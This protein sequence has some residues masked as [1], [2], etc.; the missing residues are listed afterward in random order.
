MHI[1]WKK[2]LII[3][4][5]WLFKIVTCAAVAIT[6]YL[7]MDFTCI[8]AHGLLFRS[9]SSTIY[10]YNYTLCVLATLFVFTT[11]N[12]SFV[13]NINFMKYHGV[14]NFGRFKFNDDSSCSWLV[15]D[16]KP[17]CTEQ[18]YKNRIYVLEISVISKN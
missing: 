18:K 3:Q 11:Y 1:H 14:G 10:T 15:L 8:C 2:L 9:W 5:V 4:Y 6:Y 7:C 16:S 17:S 12:H 13:N